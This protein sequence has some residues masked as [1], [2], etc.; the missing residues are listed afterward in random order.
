MS[1][2]SLWLIDIIV[3]RTV[4]SFLPLLV[5]TGFSGTMDLLIRGE[6]FISVPAHGHLGPVSQLHAI[7]G[8]RDLPYNNR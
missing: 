4:S 1:C 5:Y 3:G 7:V 2:W 8:N 6:V